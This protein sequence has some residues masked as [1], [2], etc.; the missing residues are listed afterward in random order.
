MHLVLLLLLL[1]NKLT[2]S[3]TSNYFLNKLFTHSHIKQSKV[4]YS[5]ALKLKNFSSATVSPLRIIRSPYARQTPD[6]TVPHCL[7][8]FEIVD[9][10]HQRSFEGF[11][12]SI[13]SDQN[14]PPL[15]PHPF[16]L[17]FKIYRTFSHTFYA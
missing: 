17:Y 14:Y 15:L 11:L 5:R 3:L 4:F 6:S 9:C 10:T 7:T 13:S 1:K 8:P 2:Y 16:S 12:I